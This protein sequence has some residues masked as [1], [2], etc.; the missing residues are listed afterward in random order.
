LPQTGLQCIL[1]PIELFQNSF[2]CDATGLLHDILQ[3]VISGRDNFDLDYLLLRENEEYFQNII[4]H[5]TA[6]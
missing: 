5:P 6:F 1:I 2:C 4:Y 3:S